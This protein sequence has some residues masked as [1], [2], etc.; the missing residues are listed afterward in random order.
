MKNNLMSEDAFNKFDAYAEAFDNL[1]DIKFFEKKQRKMAI[2]K[3]C[4]FN[5]KEDKDLMVTY[6]EG[7]IKEGVLKKKKNGSS[8]Q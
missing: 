7:K 2:M 3:A 8:Y 5:K 4:G 1:M 6:L